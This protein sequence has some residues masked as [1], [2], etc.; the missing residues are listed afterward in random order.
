M[1][2]NETRGPVPSMTD[3]DQR[4][5]FAAIRAALTAAWRGFANLMDSELPWLRIVDGLQSPCPQTD[6]LELVQMRLSTCYA[7]V[8]PF[9]SGRH[10]GLMITPNTARR[11]LGRGQAQPQFRC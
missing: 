7:R 4:T 11:G 8:T 3:A 10:C 2:T 1:R 5:Y 9:I 6:E